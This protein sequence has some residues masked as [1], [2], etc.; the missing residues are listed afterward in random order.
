MNSQE[1]Q[2]V[3]AGAGGIV[4]S[5]N[6][7]PWTEISKKYETVLKKDNK[8]V[9]IKT[10]GSTSVE[11]VL[12]ALIENF[13]VEAGNVQIQQNQTGSGDGHKRV[14]GAE[15]DGANAASIGFASR[16]FSSDEDVSKALVSGVICKDAVVVLVN[17]ANPITNITADQA[18]AI[19]GG[20]SKIWSDVK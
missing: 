10:A 15:K 7:K 1:G 16:D 9:V 13:T 5:T 14:L 3:I 18:K 4:D 17:A 2:Q 12:T 11:K 8:S 6:A 19:F 20:T